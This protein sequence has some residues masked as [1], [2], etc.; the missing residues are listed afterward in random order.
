MAHDFLFRELTEDEEAR[1]AALHER[2]IVVDTL[3]AIHPDDDYLDG[4]QR[5]GVTAVAL[6]M[7]SEM[8]DFRQ[9]MEKIVHWNKQIRKRSHQLVLAESAEAIRAAKAE[10]RIA[11]IYLFQNG[12]AYMDEPG[13]VEVFR[14]LGVTSSQLTYERQN[15]LGAGC[16]AENDCALTRLGERVVEALNEC[17]MLVDISHAGDQMARDILRVSKGPVY[18]SHGGCRSIRDTKR[19]LDDDTIRQV[20]ES[21]GMM[22][23][24][25]TYQPV[26]NGRIPQLTN[27]VDHTMKLI[28]LIGA[29]NV[30]MST[31]FLKE[32]DFVYRNG[33]IDEEGYLTCWYPGVL[34]PM[35]WKWTGE[36]KPSEYP[37]FRYPR[38]LETYSEYKNVTRELV[39][40][41][42]SDEQI[43]GILGGN[44]LRLY[45]KVVG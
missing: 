40:R 25:C 37:W 29:E 45:E 5:G 1:A 6:T 31:D 43:L 4:L 14:K 33:Y 16:S 21:G 7:G 18:V 13:F 2:A 23:P 17:G 34:R 11:V 26:T 8:H 44:Y 12:R 30:G 3:G 32:R 9:V 24:T 15:F 27:V 10:G 19:F 35:R 36:D 39:A 22:S 28:E 42:L 20:A 38:G 41:G